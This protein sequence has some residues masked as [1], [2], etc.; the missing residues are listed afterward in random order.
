MHPKK[1]AIAAE[2]SGEGKDDSLRT[3][4]ANR[5]W[6]SSS[7]GATT[8]HTA[9]SMTWAKSLK[10]QSRWQRSSV[11]CEDCGARGGAS[12][13]SH[14]AGKCLHNNGPFRTALVYG[15]GWSRF[16][17]LFSAAY[18]D[19]VGC[20]TVFR[21]FWLPGRYGISENRDWPGRHLG[22]DKLRDGHRLGAGRYP[23]RIFH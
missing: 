14:W 7:V 11:K 19:G 6:A 3:V 18:G 5:N 10:T 23:D 8:A 20:P 12:V 22:V 1:N 16:N 4:V 2:P 21:A 15:G 13:R 17:F 9:A